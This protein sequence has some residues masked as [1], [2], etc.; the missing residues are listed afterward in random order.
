MRVKLDIQ[1]VAVKQLESAIWMYAYNYDE[2]AVHTIASAAFEL[3]SKRLRLSNFKREVQRFIKKE[4]QKDFFS[5]WNRPYNFFK[6]GEHLNKPLEF[7]E[8]DEE[9]VELP[10]YLAAEANL[11]GPEEYRLNCARVYKYYYY[12]KHP[13]I[14][15]TDFYDEHFLEPVL[16]AGISLETLKDKHSIQFWLE[17]IGHT[18]VNGT[19]SPFRDIDKKR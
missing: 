15:E 8:Y 14:F 7:I 11:L 6:H 13:E 2:V 4:K 10:L 9:A 3:Y 12:L 1:T 19:D 5:L 18:F 16:E 17:S